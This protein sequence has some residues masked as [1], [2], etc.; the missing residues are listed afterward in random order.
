MAEEGLDLGVDSYDHYRDRQGDDRE[1]R[2][3][4]DAAP[5]ASSRGTHEGLVRDP[6]AAHG[7]AVG[8][9][10][11]T[12]EWEG[13]TWPILRTSRKTEA[14]YVAENVLAAKIAMTRDRL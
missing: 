14:A 13:K 1:A 10:P 7:A 9:R 8:S 3:E 6:P 5:S 11:A 2:E 4:V 12:V